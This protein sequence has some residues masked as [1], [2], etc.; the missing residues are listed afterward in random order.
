LLIQNTVSQYSG[1]QIK[2][3]S[4]VF[5]GVCTTGECAKN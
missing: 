2:D 3:H 1:I 5:Y 4:L